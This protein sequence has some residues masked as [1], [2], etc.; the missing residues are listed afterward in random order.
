MRKIL[1]ELR[2]AFPD[3]RIRTTGSNHYAVTLSNGRIVV[4]SNTASDLNFMR[5]V[6]ADARRQSKKRDEPCRTE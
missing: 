4:V 1:R 3:A 6:L 5:H 2:R